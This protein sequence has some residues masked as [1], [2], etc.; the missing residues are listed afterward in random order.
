MHFLAC[1]GFFMLT[2]GGDDDVNEEEGGKADC[3]STLLPTGL[4]T[5]YCLLPYYG[6]DFRL[7]SILIFLS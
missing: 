3:Q 2:D 4:C 1:F 5:A 7:G 6:S